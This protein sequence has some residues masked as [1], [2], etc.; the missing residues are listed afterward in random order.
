MNVG[1]IM[2][3]VVLLF[4]EH[5]SLTCP[6]EQVLSVAQ[7]DFQWKITELLEILDV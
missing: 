1:V 6:A 5:V 3:P 4:Q 2:K 7:L